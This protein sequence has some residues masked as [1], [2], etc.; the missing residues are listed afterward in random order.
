MSRQ[1]LFTRWK[2]EKSEVQDCLKERNKL[3][4]ELTDLCFLSRW[5][6]K[7]GA[8]VKFMR[9]Y[10]MREKKCVIPLQSS[11]WKLG[12]GRICKWKRCICIY[13][14]AHF[15]SL[16][17]SQINPCLKVLII[18][19]TSQISFS[20]RQAYLSWVEGTRCFLSGCDR[21]VLSI[22]MKS[23]EE[24]HNSLMTV[25]ALELIF[26]M[27]KILM[28]VREPMLKILFRNYQKNGLKKQAIGKIDLLATIGH[29]LCL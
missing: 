9:I 2:V 15:V 18:R 1:N 21:K 6:K 7:F 10:Q 29:L 17:M 26:L 27:T 20:V 14:I 12:L 16:K 11:W 19:E 8:N 3:G 22:L 13:I 24:R 25:E 23:I 4:H 5:F 28:S